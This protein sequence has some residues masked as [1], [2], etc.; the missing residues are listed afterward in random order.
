MRTGNLGFR[1]VFL[2]GLLVTLPTLV[3]AY[4]LLEMFYYIDGILQPIF[5]RI[6]H[7]HIPGLGFFAL[8]MLI[9]L[10]GLFASHFLGARILRAIT[11]R[12]ERVPLWSPVYRAVREL[13]EVFFSDHSRSFRR[14]A[15][16]PFPRPG[17]YALVFVTS[18]G[19]TPGD[20]AIGQDLVGVFLPTTPNPT[21]GFYLMVPRH[22]LIHVDLSIEQAL[23]L[24]ISGGAAFDP[25]ARAPVAT[26]TGS[27]NG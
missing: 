13:S 14:V 3:T 26:A 8:L 16:I 17:N 25:H 7:F 20:A 4:V 19:P 6:F 10:M 22:E 11:S 9:L 18:E 24:I 1:R 27:A 15:L 2:T 5:T 12:L 21:S 23:K